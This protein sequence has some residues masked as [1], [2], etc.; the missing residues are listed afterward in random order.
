MKRGYSEPQPWSPAPLRIHGLRLGERIKV[1]P[2]ARADVALGAFQIAAVHALQQADDLQ[3]GRVSSREL[4]EASLG[5]ADA[6][7]GGLNAIV[8]TRG[9]AALRDADESDETFDE[10]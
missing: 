10:S 6:L 1:D 9:E 3:E 4:V 2:V 5:R 8:G 7:S